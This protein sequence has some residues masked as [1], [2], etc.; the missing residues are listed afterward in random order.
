MYCPSNAT[1]HCELLGWLPRIPVGMPYRLWMNLGV[2]QSAGANAVTNVPS[3]EL[4]CPE[5][6]VRAESVSRRYAGTVICGNVHT[7]PSTPALATH[8][9]AKSADVSCWAA[10]H[11]PL[12]SARVA[13][14]TCAAGG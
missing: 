6:V 9:V 3:P 10:V 5:Y 2:A 1:T 4:S 8:R 12:G 7:T 11:T 14:T 13:D